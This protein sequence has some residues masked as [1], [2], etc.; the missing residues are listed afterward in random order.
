MMPKKVEVKTA[1]EKYLEPPLPSVAAAIREKIHA[2]N[3]AYANAKTS[4]SN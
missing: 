1:W 4:L 3:K 2:H